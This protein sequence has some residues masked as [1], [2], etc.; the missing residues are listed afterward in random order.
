MG[1][2]IRSS[3]LQSREVLTR[4][5]CYIRERLNNQQLPQLSVADCRVLPGVTTELHRL[6]VDEWY[7][8]IEG[9]GEVEIDG[10]MPVAVAVGDTVVI[11]RGSSQRISNTGSV[12]LLFECVC[13]P[14]FTTP[15][16]E[17]LE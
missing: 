8:I 7:L 1:H 2:V 17:A 9:Q 5:R 16:Y 13:V 15:C 3:S 4:E 12:D 6:L 10:S 11:P 14:R